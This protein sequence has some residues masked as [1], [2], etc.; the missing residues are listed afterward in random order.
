MVAP[1][2]RDQKVEYDIRLSLEAKQSVM[3]VPPVTKG[4]VVDHGGHRYSLEVT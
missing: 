1:H 4:Q 2:T 3:V